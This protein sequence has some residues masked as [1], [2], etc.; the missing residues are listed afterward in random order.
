MSRAAAT[1]DPRAQRTRCRRRRPRT[2][3]RAGAPRAIAFDSQS[4]GSRAA[5]HSRASR[6]HLPGRRRPTGRPSRRRSRTPPPTEPARGDRPRGARSLSP[7][8][9]TRAYRED[10]MQRRWYR[11]P[12][13]LAATGDPGVDLVRFRAA[14]LPRPRGLDLL[15]DRVAFGDVLLE[16]VRSEERRVGKEWRYWMMTGA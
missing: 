2:P 12:P 11:Q 9:Q 16:D 7:P 6:A 14:R 8:T 4:N 15:E 1:H 13:S 3:M 10:S 5:L